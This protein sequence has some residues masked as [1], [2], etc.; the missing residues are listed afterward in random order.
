MAGPHSPSG[1]VSINRLASFGWLPGSISQE[2]YMYR[3]NWKDLTTY[4]ELKKQL[5]QAI[6]DH[7]VARFREIL[8][9]MNKQLPEWR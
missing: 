7:D 4:S 5:W 6:A 3:A 9:L 1:H 8:F 2:D